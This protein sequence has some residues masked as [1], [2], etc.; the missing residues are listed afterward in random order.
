[1]ADMVVFRNVFF[2]TTIG[3]RVVSRKPRQESPETW[4][5]RTSTEGV[6]V[7]FSIT[8]LSADLLWGGLLPA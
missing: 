1:M 3:R 8:S 6:Q 4:Q 2:S 7:T 5:L